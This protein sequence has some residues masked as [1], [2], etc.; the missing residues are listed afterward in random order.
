[1][2][3]KPASPPTVELTVAAIVEQADRFL[4]VEELVCG[5]KVINQPAGH[6]ESGENPLEAVIR[7]TLEETACRF[8]PDAVTGIYLW[9][10][11]N[12]GKSFLRV[13]FCGSCGDQDP[14]RG[15]DEGILRTLWVSRGDLGGGGHR[16]RSPMVMRSIEDYLGGVRLPLDEVQSVSVT[17]L[18]GRAAV[19]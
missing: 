14:E 11:P 19:I 15:L 16:L 5:E 6:V 9:R 17:D 1:M 10:S 13:S 3:P 2:I 7:E 8:E 12:D 18:A 4:M